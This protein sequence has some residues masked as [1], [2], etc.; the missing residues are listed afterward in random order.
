MTERFAQIGLV[1]LPPDSR[2]DIASIRGVYA[3]VLLEHRAAA[4]VG[5]CA[6][7]NLDGSALPFSTRA[8]KTAKAFNR[9]DPLTQA[10]V[11]GVNVRLY[12]THCCLNC[13][14]QLKFQLC[15]RVVFGSSSGE[16]TGGFV[17]CGV[18]GLWARP[19]V[20]PTSALSIIAWTLLYVRA[21]HVHSMLAMF[22]T[23]Y[24]CSCLQIPRPHGTSLLCVQLLRSTS[25]LLH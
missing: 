8:P 23:V 11:I 1:H 7:E 25:Q 24:A 2:G 6:H 14:A 16:W 13:Q 17:G 9:S 20:C 18:S 10:P 12:E 19:G 22:L 3:A 15:T 4:P 21:R 5:A